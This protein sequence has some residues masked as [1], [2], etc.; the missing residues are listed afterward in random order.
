MA[1]TFVEKV[2]LELK[3]AERYAV[4]VSLVVLDLS[5]LQKQFGSNA[6][7]LV[8]QVCDSIREKVRDIDSVSTLGSLR[9]GF[10]LPETPR[11]GAEIASRR[12][13]EQ[14]RDIILDTESSAADRVIPIE[15]ASYPDAAGNRTIKQFLEDFAEA[16]RN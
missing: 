9:I 5:F 14:I 4:F 3:R 13:G 7:G 12:I 15:M 11:Q 10:L 1:N 16:S 2:D 6:A 8:A